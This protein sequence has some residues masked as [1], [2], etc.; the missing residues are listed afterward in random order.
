M[1]PAEHQAPACRAEWCSWTPFPA[2]TPWRFDLCSPFLVARAGFVRPAGRVA[3]PT[4]VGLGPSGV[5][6]SPYGKPGRVT[7]STSDTSRVWARAPGPGVADGVLGRC[8][9]DDD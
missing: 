1:N 5:G 8:L 9:E 6:A 3:S 7:A 2:G 4:M